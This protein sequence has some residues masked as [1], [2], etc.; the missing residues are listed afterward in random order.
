[1]I[2]G[3]KTCAENVGGF[4]VGVREFQNALETLFNVH[5]LLELEANNPEHVRRYLKL[6]DPA[7]ETLLLLSRSGVE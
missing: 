3:V 1:M 5:Y 4:D 6:A 7:L 2:P